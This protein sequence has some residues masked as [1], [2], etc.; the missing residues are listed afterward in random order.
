MTF[1]FQV[2]ITLLAELLT[3]LQ[4]EGLKLNT[5][6]VQLMKSEVKV[7]GI[8]I[9]P[10][11]KQPLQ[12]RIEAIASLPVKTTFKALRQFSGLVNFSRDFIVSLAEKVKPLYDLLK[13]KE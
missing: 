12:E 4:E 6:K 11:K 2:K 5:C 8:L 13:N 1:F 10:G 9:G 3:I 7:L